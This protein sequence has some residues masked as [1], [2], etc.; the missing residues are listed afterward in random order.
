M[1]LY[2]TYNAIYNTLP[3]IATVYY[4]LRHIL[5][6]RVTLP[7]NRDCN[8]ILSK[9]SHPK[10]FNRSTHG[11]RKQAHLKVT[12]TLTFDHVHLSRKTFQ[13]CNNGY[14]NYWKN[15]RTNSPLL[16]SQRW[17]KD[18]FRWGFPYLQFQ[19]FCHTRPRSKTCSSTGRS[20]SD[21]TL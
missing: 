19:A 16:T 6:D 3:L 12:V 5:R 20:L 21:R 4:F 10:L 1:L 7:S 13:I 9:V 8:T 18:P 11:S 15:G 17:L 2:R 14:F